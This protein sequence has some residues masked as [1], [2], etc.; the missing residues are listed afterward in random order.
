MRDE[1]IEQCSPTELRDALKYGKI[2]AASW[3]PLR[4]YGA[5][6]VAAQAVTGRGAQLAKEIGRETVQRDLSG[7]YRVFVAMLSP[8]WI[9]SKGPRFYSQYYDTGRM[10]VIFAERGEGAARFVGCVDFDANI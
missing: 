10:E 4:W 1:M 6:H 8:A 5:L 9:L 3:Y 7:V 2:V